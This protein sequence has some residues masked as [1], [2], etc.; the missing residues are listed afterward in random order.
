MSSCVAIRGLEAPA[1]ARRA[2]SP[3]CAVSTSDVPPVRLSAC[4]PGRAQLDPGPFGER[5]HPE[6]GEQLVGT[7][8]LVPGGSDTPLAAQ[9]LPIQ[10]M[11]AVQVHAQRG[12]AEVVD[13]LAVA[14]LGG[15]TFADQRARAPRARSPERSAR[16]LASGLPSS[17]LSFVVLPSRRL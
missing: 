1:L 16:H 5:L 9:P 15:L 8:Q 10:Q 3:S 11:G 13:G 4:A 2:I 6:A 14:G 17:S 7:A 12:A